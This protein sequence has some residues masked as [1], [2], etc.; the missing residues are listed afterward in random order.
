MIADRRV[1]RRQTAGSI[2]PPP[3]DG[4]D[5]VGKVKDIGSAGGGGVGPGTVDSH[6][7]AFGYSRFQCV[8]SLRS[9]RA[10]IYKKKN[11]KYVLGN[12]G[13]YSTR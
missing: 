9:E 7:P 5:T 11:K 3:S 4:Y 12:R 1:L 8:Y 6:G 2:S 10:C 13:F